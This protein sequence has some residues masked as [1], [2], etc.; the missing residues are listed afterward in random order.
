MH[1]TWLTS[2]LG[3]VSQVQAN[4]SVSDTFSYFESGG[5]FSFGQLVT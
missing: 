2:W 1:K 4:I 5:T 3:T